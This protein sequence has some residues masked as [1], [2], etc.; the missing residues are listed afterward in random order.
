[1]ASKAGM[2]KFMTDTGPN[3]DRDR[4]YVMVEL[5]NFEAAAT[6]PQ[7]S[8]VM[9][10]EVLKGPVAV[11]CSCGRWRYWYAYMATAGGYNAN[12]EHKESAFP[13]IRNPKLRGIA[14][15]HILR[16]MQALKSSPSMAGF[17]ARLG[18]RP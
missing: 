6:S 14:C 12:P 3:S 2:L 10:K 9:A 17:V 13:K 4:H 5:R 16:T 1:M 8:M 11:A 7:P 18:V 15:K